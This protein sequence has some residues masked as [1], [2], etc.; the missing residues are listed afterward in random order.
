VQKSTVLKHSLKYSGFVFVEKRTCGQESPQD[1][2]DGNMHPLGEHL[3]P[4]AK[5]H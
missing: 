1:T 4:N 2:E 5:E 3:I